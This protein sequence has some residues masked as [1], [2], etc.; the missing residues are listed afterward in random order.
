MHCYVH[1]SLPLQLS[2]SSYCHT[3]VS[4]GCNLYISLWEHVP[5]SGITRD[6]LLVYWLPFNSLELQN[7]EPGRYLV[8]GARTVPLPARQMMNSETNE[9]PQTS[10]I[11]PVV[12]VFVSCN[13]QLYDR[14]L[15]Y[16]PLHKQN[17][18]QSILLH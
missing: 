6:A 8:A 7:M 14:H 13:K 1:K 18:K 10:H 11:A 2:R 4:L 5:C 15:Q 9:R 12:F 17:N 3:C 16:K